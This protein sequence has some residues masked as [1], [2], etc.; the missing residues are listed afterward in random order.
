MLNRKCKNL[1]L[2]IF[3]TL[4]VSLTTSA[5]SQDTSAEPKRGEKPG[6]LILAHGAPTPRW[7]EAIAN[8]AEKVS[9]VNAEKK[10]FHAVTGAMMEF[11]Q[12][13]AATGIETLEKAGCDRIIVAPVFICPTS[14]THFDVPA[15]LG[16][17]SSPSVRQTLKSENARIAT[18]RVP[19]TMTQT[20]SEGD[21]LARYLSDELATL[22]TNPE[23]EAIV[24]I[25]H[26]DAGHAGLIDA[27]MKRLMNVASEKSGVTTVENVYCGVGQTYARNV[28]PV[29]QKLGKDKKRVI[30]VGFYL[31]SSA[32]SI[33]DAG[34]RMGRMGMGRG[35]ERE[36]PAAATNTNPSANPYEGIDVLFSEKGVIEHPYTPQWILECATEAL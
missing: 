17:Y 6:L 27:I 7:A 16:L 25:S 14:H 13:D 24:L 35:M 9:E 4:A 23:E 18:P 34:S 30:V 19:V 26:G 32:K 8:L 2:M 28:I 20:I 31:V 36:N 11:A 12:P 1:I 5:R 3:C 21:L 10:V 29:V 33:H 22:S 15:V